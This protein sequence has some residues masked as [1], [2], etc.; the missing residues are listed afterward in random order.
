MSRCFS[1]PYVWFSAIWLCS[2]N[3]NWSKKWI[4]R[5][6][7]LV[8]I[9]SEVNNT[10][11]AET[12]NFGHD[13]SLHWPVSPI[14]FAMISS[15]FFPSFPKNFPIKPLYA[16]VVCPCHPTLAI[17]SAS[18]PAVYATGRPYTS[19]SR[20]SSWCDILNFTI[21]WSFVD[22]VLL[23]SIYNIFKLFCP[24]FYWDILLKFTLIALTAF[25]NCICKPLVWRLYTY[26]TPR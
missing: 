6:N 23:I 9:T 25:M 10:I 22:P 15:H 18:K 1:F 21:N 2:W 11:V 24:Y 16:F 12:G 26:F 5:N 13:A 19:T 8:N 4:I 17:W 3:Q 20:S 7:V 14:I